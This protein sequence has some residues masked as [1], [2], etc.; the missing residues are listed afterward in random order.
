MALQLRVGVLFYPQ[1]PHSM[2]VDSD[3]TLTA[4]VLYDAEGIR[5]R[6][7]A[8]ATDRLVSVLAQRSQ[9]AVLERAEGSGRGDVQLAGGGLSLPDQARLDMLEPAHN[10]NRIL[11]QISQQSPSLDCSHGKL[12]SYALLTFGYSDHDHFLRP[13]CT[14]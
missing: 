7:M 8:Q 2:A 13:T 5:V 14:L 6:Q 9:P 4:R 10:G 3:S 1:T 11:D 12:H